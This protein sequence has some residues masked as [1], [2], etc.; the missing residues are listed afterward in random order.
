MKKLKIIALLSFVM[1]VSVMFAACGKNNQEV[2]INFTVGYQG[3]GFD[4]KKKCIVKTFSEWN[5]LKP[6]HLAITELDKYIWSIL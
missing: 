2:N 6:D 1:V 3:A 4:Q 5:T